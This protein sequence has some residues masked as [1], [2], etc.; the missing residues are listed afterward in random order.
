[1]VAVGVPENGTLGGTRIGLRVLSFEIFKNYTLNPAYG[2]KLLKNPR[3]PF[4]LVLLVDSN[5]FLNSNKF[6]GKE[7][8]VI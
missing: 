6:E 2:C 8:A 5:N 4:P 7:P 3:M 1:L